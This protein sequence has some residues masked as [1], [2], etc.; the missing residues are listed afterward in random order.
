MRIV[1]GEFKGA[2]FRTPKGSGV[3]PTSAL[4]K[5]SLFAMLEN[6]KD[7]NA[8]F[9]DLYAGSGALGLEA[10][11]RGAGGVDFVEQNERSA[12]LIK[13]NLADLGFSDTARV[14]RSPVKKALLFLDKKY[15]FVLLDPPYDSQELNAVLKLLSQSKIT[16]NGALLAIPHSH[17]TYLEE[18]YGLFHLVRRRRHGDTTISIYLKE[19]EKI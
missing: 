4:V 8:Q 13:K 2:T 5:K 10:L 17:R 18:A 3:R 1:A 19:E 15:D 6:L 11:S 16:N 7:M 14:Y 12:V 9:L